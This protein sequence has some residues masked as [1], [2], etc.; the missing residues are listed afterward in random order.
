M[1]QEIL[2]NK[3]AGLLFIVKQLF[4]IPMNLNLDSD[5]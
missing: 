1:E 5:G 3:R 2:P 4:R